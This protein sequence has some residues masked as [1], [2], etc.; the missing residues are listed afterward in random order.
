LK[1][2]TLFGSPRVGIAGI[3]LALKKKPKNIF[4]FR[5]DKS[6]VTVVGHCHA[7]YQHFFLASPLSHRNRKTLHCKTSTVTIQ[8]IGIHC[9]SSNNSKR[10]TIPRIQKDFIKEKIRI[11]SP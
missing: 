9:D 11:K 1:T 6:Y 8:T 10:L 4:L 2:E 5:G 3:K 7:K